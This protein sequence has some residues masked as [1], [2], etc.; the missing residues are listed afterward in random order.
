MVLANLIDT[1]ERRLHGDPKIVNVH[2]YDPL[3][4]RAPPPSRRLDE[5]GLFLDI[6]FDGSHEPPN[7]ENGFAKL[8]AGWAFVVVANRPLY[9]GQ[10]IERYSADAYV[11]FRRSGS[12]CTDPGWPLWI[13]ARKHSNNTGELSAFAESMLWFV[14][15]S[16]IECRGC[17]VAFFFDSTLAGN[18][19][20]GD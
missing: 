12:V 8:E 7:F 4:V 6:Y 16:P 10:Q 2:L 14:F 20:S 18:Q 19:T 1:L 3:N 9:C 15:E 5:V 11:V 13:G 17:A